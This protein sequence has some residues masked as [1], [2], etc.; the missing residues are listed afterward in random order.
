MTREPTGQSSVA[1]GGRASDLQPLL[2]CTERGRRYASEGS[3]VGTF[4]DVFVRLWQSPAIT[5]TND[6]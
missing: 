4:P 2:L 1:E 6:T 3:I 5:N